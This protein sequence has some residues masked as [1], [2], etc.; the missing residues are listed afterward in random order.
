MARYLLAQSQANQSGV[1]TSNGLDQNTS[2]QIVSGVL[3]S[4]A[5]TTNQ[6]VVYTA[7]N[8]N[9]QSNSNETIVINYFEVI[10]KNFQ[11]MSNRSKQNGSEIDII[12]NAILNQ[13]QNEIAKLDPI[14]QSYQT[15]LSAML[16][17]PVPAEVTS[18]HL[19]FV[20]SISKVLSDLQA[21]R[22]SF[23]DPVKSLAALST[24]KQDYTDMGSAIQKLETYMQIKI[25]SFE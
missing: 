6:T 2:D 21:I 13:D 19:E 7:K 1:D 5:Y 25:K 12:N 22:G 18:L 9:I 16:K 20:N 24:Y 4:G 15:L 17:A 14:I 11:Q 10:L 8:L 3:S 23:I